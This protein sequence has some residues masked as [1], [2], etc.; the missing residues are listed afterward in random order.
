MKQETAYKVIQ[1]E[2][3]FLG[4]SFFETLVDIK[5]WETQMYSERVVE[6]FEIVFSDGQKMFYGTLDK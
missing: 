5:K 2:A 6:A 4:K 1:D 3:D